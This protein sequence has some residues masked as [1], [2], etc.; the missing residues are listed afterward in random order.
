MSV[1]IFGV[2]NKEWSSPCFTYC[3]Y[4]HVW[5][6]VGI[7]TLSN[8]QYFESKVRLP[9]VKLHGESVLLYF[10]TAVLI[11]G[12]YV[13]FVLVWHSCHLNQ[14]SFEGCEGCPCALSSSCENKGSTCYICTSSE[15]SHSSSS[16]ICLYQDFD[17]GSE[18]DMLY[19]S[20]F[21]V[22]T[23]SC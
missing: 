19:P 2:H 11:Q 6:T 12:F 20:C 23:C 7:H 13:P 14:K 5:S 3:P 4:F 17:L 10:W 8:T 9:L 18:N 15:I 21:E 22:L 16:C 1:G